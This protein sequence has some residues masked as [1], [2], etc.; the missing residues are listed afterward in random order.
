MNPIPILSA[1]DVHE[2]LAARRPAWAANYHAMYSS[3]FGGIVTDPALMLVPAD[4]HVVH[5]GDG[6]FETLKCVG[7]AVYAMSKSALVGRWMR[8][9]D[10]RIHRFGVQRAGR[11]GTKGHAER[12]HPGAALCLARGDHAEW[13][14]LSPV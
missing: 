4:D 6:V 12:A 2:R 3:V 9:L 8:A 11:R 10:T 1:A 14:G 13:R 5:R 7:G